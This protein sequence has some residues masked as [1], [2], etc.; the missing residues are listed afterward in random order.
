MNNNLQ[1]FLEAVLFSALMVVFMWLYCRITP[2]QMSAEYDLAVQ[3]GE[4]AALP[5]NHIRVQ[6]HTN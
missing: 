2:P 6:H 5:D 3:A 4:Q 1:N